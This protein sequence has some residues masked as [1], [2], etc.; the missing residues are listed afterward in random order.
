VL[1][2]TLFCATATPAADIISM[3]LLAIPMVFLYFIAAG[4]A[5]IHDRGAAK[6]EAALEAELA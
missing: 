3:V 1:V 5:W 2:I 4:V 6:R